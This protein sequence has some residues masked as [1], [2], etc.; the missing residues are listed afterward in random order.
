[1]MRWMAWLTAAV[2]LSATTAGASVQAGPPDAVIRN[3][4]I[5]TL[6]ERGVMADAAVVVRD[7]RIAEII[8]AAV[9][10]AAARVI[11]GQGGWLMAG[12][13]DAHVHYQTNP[14]LAGYLRYGVTTVLSLGSRSPQLEGMIEARRRQGAEDLVGAHLYGTGP[15]V[16]NGQA[17]ENPDDVP[18]YLD[19][20]QTD[21]AGFVKVYNGISQP[22]FER[23]V[24]EA[25]ARNMGIFGHMPRGFPVAQALTGGLNVLAHME[26]LFFTEFGG[27]RDAD[28][29]AMAPD[30]A[31][32]LSKVE[33]L[34]DLIAEN[35]VI[36]IPNLAISAGYAG[37]WRDEGIELSAPDMAYWPEDIASG[38]REGNYSHR[39]NIERRIMREQI[40]YPL[41]RLLTYRAQQRGILLLTGTDAPLPPM[42]PGRSLHQEL[43]LLVAAG[44]TREQALR[45]ATVNGG[46]AVSRYVDRNACIGV[47]RP[48][49]EADLVLLRANPLEDIRNTE[50]VIG[51]MTDGHWY[52]RDELDELARPVRP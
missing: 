25:R 31:P 37:L 34:L 4:N 20:L 32:D 40:K 5:V 48:G 45:A 19:R 2:A 22:V 14:E 26:E 1:M 52:L 42:Y 15:A 36:I 6:D 49:C 39:P 10:P 47:I 7:G 18:A 12:L 3:V 30:W 9:A 43:R 28:L 17:I 51:V 24:Q 33:P 35:D 8:D 29:D 23:L 16:A 46:I 50:G 44:L 27:P 38:W 11:N 13:I 41:I 21:G